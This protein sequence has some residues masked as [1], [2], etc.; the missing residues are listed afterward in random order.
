MNEQDNVFPYGKF[1]TTST[2]RPEE[3]I[4]AVLNGVQQNLMLLAQKIEILEHKVNELENQNV[5]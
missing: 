2:A 3:R 5:E 1:D 4:L